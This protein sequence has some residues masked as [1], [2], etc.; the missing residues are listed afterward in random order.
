MSDE[1]PREPGRSRDDA[2]RRSSSQR[3]KVTER[4]AINC[5]PAQKAAIKE[6]VAAAGLSPSAMCLAVLL[7]VP[8]PRRRLPSI[9]DQAMMAYIAANAKL[10]DALKASLAE[11]GK[12]NSNV[13]QIAHMLNTNIDPSRIMNIIESGVSNHTALIDTYH[14]AIEDDLKELRTMAMDALGLEH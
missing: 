12:V 2:P 4:I 8:L 6:K 3:R 14:R 10:S 9:N 5:T 11:L 1:S 13:N 7:D